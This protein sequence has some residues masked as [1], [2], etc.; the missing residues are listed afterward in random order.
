MDPDIYDRCSWDELKQNWSMEKEH[1]L[2]LWLNG[3]STTPTVESNIISV[4]DEK[5]KSSS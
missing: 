4:V 5:Q 2:D 3:G 1:L